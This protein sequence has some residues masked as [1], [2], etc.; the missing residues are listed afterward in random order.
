MTKRA[1]WLVGLN[2]LIPGSAQLLAGSRTLG[3]F[4]VRAT[5]SL[6][7]AVAV[8]VVVFLLWPTP[9]YWVATNVIALT[10][11]Q[12]VLAAYAVL[13]VVLTIDTLRLVRI[14]RA[15]PKARPAIAALSVGLLVLS[16]GVV[17]YGSMVAGVTRDTVSSMFADGNYQDP[18]D[19]RYNILL[20][21][22]DAGPDRTGMRPDSLSVVS[23]DADTGAT[24]MIGV[25][26]NFE[27]A[28]FS[29]GSP[30]WGEFPDGYDCGDLCLV[31]YLYTY[32][33]EHPELYP[34]A[35]ANGS[36][37]GIEATRDAVSGITGL[38]LQYYVLVDMQGFADL[39]DSLG[40][41]DIDV[42]ER[43]PYGPI[44]STEP[45]GYFEAGVQRMD[46]AAALWYARSRFEAS[47]YDRMERQRQVQEAMLAQ[48]EPRN[49]L[50]KFQGIAAAGSQVV[51]TDVP[52]GILPRF[53][54]MGTKARTQ[55]I[56]T[57]ELVPDLV[58]T[59]EP[60]YEYIHALVQQT[61][62]AA[63]AAG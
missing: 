17:G 28:Q 19:G 29:E 60:D 15:W 2:F 16:A 41:I 56:T 57:L 48:F 49:V 14:V 34:E 52:S 36:N 10:L 6:W 42:A 11:L 53:V 35:E 54:D 50:S 22:G 12:V 8:G 63:V 33:I 44:T 27:R 24:T 55:P 26:R 13:W 3:R 38:T 62:A 61:L 47:D 40:G 23:I 51:S 18:V 4:G 7:T 37:P 43:F 30:L 1:W 59:N 58:N 20:L 32:G 25:P 9:I 5:F 31:S 39:I 21:G 45:Y 46:G